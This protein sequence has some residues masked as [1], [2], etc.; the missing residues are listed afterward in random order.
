MEKEDEERK[1]AWI[2][3]NLVI[4]G[5]KENKQT[6]PPLPSFSESKE[7]EQAAFPQETKKLPQI[8]ISDAKTQSQIIDTHTLPKKRNVFLIWVLST[9]TLTIYTSVWY[10]QRAVELN[11]LGTHKKLSKRV[12]QTLLIINVALLASIILF[13]L[14]LSP[15]EMGSFYQ[16]TTPL[17]TMLIIIF[18]ASVILQV[19]FTIYLAFRSGGIIN[20][21][22]ENKGSG[23]RLS[24]FFTLIFTHLYIQYEINRIEDDHEERPRKGPWTWF[25]IILILIIANIVLGLI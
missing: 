8:K 17:Q 15:E 2:K 25:I 21:A 12:P 14:T 19:I 22:L 4:P 3:E 5:G 7:K 23:V 20:Q 1:Q 24:W 9:I 11:N 6:P 10:I 13:P 16:N 18:G